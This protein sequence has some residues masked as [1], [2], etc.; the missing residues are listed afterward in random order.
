MPQTQDLGNVKRL[1]I[2]ISL[3]IGA[4]FSILN[5]TLLNIAFV[6]LTIELGVSYPTIQWLST[7][8]LLVVGIL[9]PVTALL[10]Q[11]FTTRQMFLGAMS[12]FTVGTLVCALAPG[13][14]ILLVGRIIQALGTGLMLPVMMNTILVLYPPEKRGAAMGSMGLVIMFAPAIGPTLSGLIL[15]TFDWRWLFYLVLPFAV[16]S[17]IFAAVFLKNVS[18]VTRPKVD[19]LSIVLS[20]IGFG[21]IVFGFS[22]AG[23][24]GEFTSPDVYLSLIA[25]AIALTLFV[26][27]QLR[28]E[29]PMLDFRAFKFPM[30]AISTVLLI[31]AMMSMFATMM[32][33]PIYLQGALL[34]STLSAGL[35]LL[36]GSALNGFLSPITGKLFDKFGPRVLVI[37]GAVLLFTITWLFTRISLDTTQSTL[38]LY[39]ILLMV[40]ISMIMM[41]TQTNGLNQLPR[42]YYPHGTAILNT[43]QQVAGAIGVALFISIMN[44]GAESYVAQ[45]TEMPEGNV[46]ALAMN[47]GVQQAFTVGLMFAGAALLLSLFIKRTKTSGRIRRLLNCEG[48]F[49]NLPLSW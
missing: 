11:W 4:F 27:R 32:L 40:A 47:A 46:D 44:T 37:P 20:T 29:T 33:L 8:Y 35:L 22:S 34:L 2:L 43:L 16:F 15:E 25:G 28:S 23:K 6:P 36:P 24:S 9:I 45:L 31:I 21:G 26:W 49:I 5:E 39:H 30:F 18:T 13:F 19:I 14:E 41:P 42:R 17:V 12:L 7:G 10:V 48:F 1:P 38:V 3:I